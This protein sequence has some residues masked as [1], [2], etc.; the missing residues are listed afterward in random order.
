MSSPI[1]LDQTDRKILTILQKHAKITNAQ[2]S[3]D[4]DL[5]PAPTL[6]RVKKLENSGIIESYHAKLNS[7]LLGLGISAFVK[8]SLKNY[9]KQNNDSFLKRIDLV[10]EVVECHSITGEANFLIKVVA[11]DITSYEAILRD[12]V[13]SI[14]EIGKL[15]SMVIMSTV[16]DSKVVP[17]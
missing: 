12:K 16:K 5:S 2:L 14:E 13:S 8:V 10:D 11:R 7:H 1:K 6:E 15:D 17:V 9:N 3:K 4:I